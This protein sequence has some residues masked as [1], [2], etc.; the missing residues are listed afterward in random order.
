RGPRTREYLLKLGYDCPEVYGDPAILLLDYY[1]PS[2]SKKYKLGIV[3]H[4][5]DYENALKIFGGRE[6]VKV[7]DLLTMNVEATTTEILECER[8]LSTSLHGLIV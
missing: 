2:I 6:E 7:V 1:H 8:I 3:P 5:H 4:Y